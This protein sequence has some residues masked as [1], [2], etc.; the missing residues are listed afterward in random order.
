MKKRQYLFRGNKQARQKLKTFKRI[1]QQQEDYK[2][3]NDSRYNEKEYN[4]FLFGIKV[5]RVRAFPYPRRMMWKL[6]FIKD[7]RGN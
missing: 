3:L 2:R 4:D 6:G 7:I 5:L 1:V